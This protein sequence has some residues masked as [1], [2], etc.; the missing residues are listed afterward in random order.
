LNDPAGGAC[1]YRAFFPQVFL[2]WNRFGVLRSLA[3]LERDRGFYR[4]RE[5]GVWIPAMSIARRGP[6]PVASHLALF[7]Y[8][9]FATLGQALVSGREGQGW[10]KEM[11]EIVIPEDPAAADAFRLHPVV[12]DRFGHGSLGQTEQLMQ[13]VKAAGTRGGAAAQVWTQGTAALEA[14]VELLFGAGTVTIPGPGLVVKM[15]EFFLRG[16]RFV[17]LKQFRDIGRPDRACYQAVVEAGTT[18]TSF[19]GAGLLEGWYELGI[20]TCDS[21]PL[22]S[23]LGLGVETFSKLRGFFIDMDFTIDDGEEIWKA[24]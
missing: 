21:H 4:Y 8:Y 22:V 15:L 16:P 20:K 9:M 5:S 14:I 1:D 17:F 18:I 7:P 11:A 24:P 3:P 23:E 13:V 2:V 10:P 19:R 12:I 6:V